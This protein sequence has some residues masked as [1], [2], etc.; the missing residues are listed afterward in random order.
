MS[1]DSEADLV[2]QWLAKNKPTK[3]PTQDLRSTEDS[4][5]VIVPTGNSRPATEFEAEMMD[6][7]NHAPEVISAKPRKKGKPD[8]AE[9]WLGEN[10]TDFAINDE[11]DVADLKLAQGG[12]EQALARILER[13]GSVLPDISG[14]SAW[15]LDLEKMAAQMQDAVRECILSYAVPSKIALHTEIRLT[16][17]EV[18]DGIVDDFLARKNARHDRQ[19]QAYA[20]FNRENGGGFTDSIYKNWVERNAKA[21]DKREPWDIEH[22]PILVPMDYWPPAAHNYVEGLP[23]YERKIIVG[24]Y[25]E[26]M[27]VADL[28]ASLRVTPSAI[29]Q[30]KDALKLDL[31]ARFGVL[32]FHDGAPDITK[33]RKLKRIRASVKKLKNIVRTKV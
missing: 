5:A 27:S 23:A 9:S 24:L 32:P 25:D 16:A 11:D 8:L 1:S 6:V 26:G 14:Y 33:A 30:R 10:E 17:N 21:R 4:P 3:L 19:R 15:P 2:A 22:F 20:D 18:V 7:L 31:V 13:N 29:S 12:D 28:A